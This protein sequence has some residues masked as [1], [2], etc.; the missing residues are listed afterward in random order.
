MGSEERGAGS[1]WRVTGV[2]GHPTWLRVSDQQGPALPEPEREI[3]VVEVGQWGA[4]WTALR[5]A[6]RPRS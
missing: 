5:A 2:H 3:T 1:M 6:L 4:V